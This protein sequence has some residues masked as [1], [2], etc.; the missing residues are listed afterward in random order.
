MAEVQ[1]SNLKIKEDLVYGSFYER[2][3]NKLAIFNN[4]SLGCISLSSKV[5]TPG[6]LEETSFLKNF[7]AAVAADRDPDS[8]AALTEHAVS[9]GSTNKFKVFRRLGPIAWLES[10]F[11]IKGISPEQRSLKIGER[12]ADFAMHYFV[13]LAIASLT[14][15]IE[16]NSSAVVAVSGPLTHKNLLRLLRLRADDFS[17]GSLLVMDSTSYFDLVGQSI[18]LKVNDPTTLAI[19]AAQT[20]T[21]NIPVLV[22]DNDDLS[23]IAS[24]ART[25]SKVLLLNQGAITI[26]QGPIRQA[27]ERKTGGENIKQ[28]WQ[29]EYDA[30]VQVLGFSWSSLEADRKPSLGDLRT[31]S[32]WSYAYA[33]VHDGPGYR[34]QFTAS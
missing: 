11:Y 15:T 34:A 30:D 2:I 16:K 29:S 6:F 22:L 23:V 7:D 9:E 28:V 25:H 27:A 12:A 18:D 19:R 20:A 32:K 33:S 4:D 17:R 14:T 31:P 24:N 10:A 21:F 8:T 1:T 13:Q 26:D 3:K 5:L